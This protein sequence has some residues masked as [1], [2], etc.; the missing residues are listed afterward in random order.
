MC[1]L[2]YLDSDSDSES[3]S[4]SGSDWDSDVDADDSVTSVQLPPSLLV[5][6]P[7][8]SCLEPDSNFTRVLSRLFSRHSLDIHQLDLPYHD[9][10]SFKTRYM[11]LANY[12]TL[13]HSFRPALMLESSRIRSAPA[14]L[15]VAELNRFL[16]YHD[17][18]WKSANDTDP[19]DADDPEFVEIFCRSDRASVHESWNLMLCLSWSAFH[20]MFVDLAQASPRRVWQVLFS[21]RY[22][23]W[24]NWTNEKFSNEEIA[25]ASRG[26]CS[27]CDEPVGNLITRSSLQCERCAVAHLAAD[28]LVDRNEQTDPLFDCSLYFSA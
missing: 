28:S 12:R 6:N 15:T 22:D 18:H 9:P 13:C 26:L 7:T 10:E 1:D 8:T 16:I 5:L 27:V 24:F 25:L 11:T 3:E 4:G 19:P 23:G 2:D 14:R 20:Q 21:Q 17:L